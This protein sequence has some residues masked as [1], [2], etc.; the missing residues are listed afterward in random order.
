MKT[1]FEVAKANIATD[2]RDVI[3]LQYFYSLGSTEDLR[4]SLKIFKATLMSEYPKKYNRCLIES[5]N[6]TVKVLL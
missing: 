2:N 3:I 4:K 1:F 6:S 5:S